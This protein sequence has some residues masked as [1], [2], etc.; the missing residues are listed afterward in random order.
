MMIRTD[1][2]E[3]DDNHFIC[4]GLLTVFAV[5]ESFAQVTSRTGW[6]LKYGDLMVFGEG[7]G[8]DI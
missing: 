1:Y 6:S 3:K 5:G 4:R 8:C 7:T 2:A